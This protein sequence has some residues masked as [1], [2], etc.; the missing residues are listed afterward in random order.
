MEN[1]GW[2]WSMLIVALS[3]AAGVHQD[4]SSQPLSGKYT[5]GGTSPD[6]ASFSAAVAGLDSNGISGPV[7]FNVRAGTYTER[8][9]LPAIAGAS[10][11]NTI[12]FRSESGVTSDVLLQYAPAG[13]GD[14]SVIFLNNA[15]HIRIEQ[16]TV[17]SFGGVLFRAV[18]VLNDTSGTMS[19]VVIQGNSLNGVPA[20][21][22]NPFTA[23][24]VG[25][26]GLLTSN[27]T[28][29]HNT[30]NNGGYGV[31]LPAG[32]VTPSTGTVIRANTFA[33][34]A[35]GVEATNHAAIVVDSNNVSLADEGIALS[36]CSGS[37]SVQQNRVVN[38]TGGSG[39]YLGNCQGTALN[40]GLIANNFVSLQTLSAQYGISILGSSYQNFC[41]NSVSV[42]APASGVGLY[43]SGGTN[44][45]IVNNV[46]FNTSGS[47]AYDVTTPGGIAVSDHN[48]L[49]GAG[50]IFLARWGS[51]DCI[52]LA[53]L[54]AASGMDLHSVSA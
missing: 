48:D 20:N 8:V 3:L 34:C 32:R 24:V 50:M 33:G 28:I 9:V 18:I 44:I 52:S 37:L 19:D 12:T 21:G 22:R 10:D 35:G 26:A 17:A 4:A 15:S 25:H 16:M 6:F 14:N 23:L 36:A 11:T 54:Q 29:S 39:I 30:F 49:Y 51:T 40:P 7:I 13:E 27:L 42:T 41:F 1:T 38:N 45:N 31:Y 53:A 2:K 5:I 47:Y 46:F 43:Q